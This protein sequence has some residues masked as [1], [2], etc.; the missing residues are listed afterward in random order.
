VNVDLPDGVVGNYFI[1]VFTDSNIAGALP[2][3]NAGVEFEQNIS[4]TLAR[5]GEYRDE[6]NN[7]TAQPLAITLATRPICR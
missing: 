6:G 5:V 7:I 4:S 3:G 2:P 1:L